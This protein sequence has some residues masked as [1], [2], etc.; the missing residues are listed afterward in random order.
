MVREYLEELIQRLKEGREW[1]PEEEER[2]RTEYRPMAERR[3]KRDLVLEAIIRAEALGVTDE[4]VDEL[5]RGAGRDQEPGP[6]LERL[7]RNPAQRERA[8]S[9]LLERKLFALLREKA[10]LKMTA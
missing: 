2:F 4:E 1:S 10:R 5:L 9:H 8:A 6:E 7:V 3:I